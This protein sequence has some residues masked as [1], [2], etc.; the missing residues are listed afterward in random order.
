VNSQSTDR[1]LV[2]GRDNVN[3]DSE[4]DAHRALNDELDARINTRKS[5]YRNANKTKRK[6]DFENSSKKM[7]NDDD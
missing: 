5:K 3:P 6:L 1:N 2:S 4:M 7:N